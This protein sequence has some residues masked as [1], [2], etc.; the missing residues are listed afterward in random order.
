MTDIEYSVSGFWAAEPG[1][2]TVWFV[3][4]IGFPT[5]AWERTPALENLDDPRGIGPIP[6]QGFLVATRGDCRIRRHTDVGTIVLAGTGFCAGREQTGHGDGGPAT[7]AHLRFPNDV[8]PTPDGGF[9]FIERER[10]RR[11]A[12]DGTISTLF[13]TGLPGTIPPP[14][15]RSPSP[16]PS[17]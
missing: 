14:T 10:V 8:E 17:S 13:Y 1:G 15:S 3:R 2:E 9:V 6:G 12:P 5:N 4:F 11:V 16:P 7:A